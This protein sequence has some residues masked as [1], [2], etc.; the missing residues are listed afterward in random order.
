MATKRIVRWKPPNEFYS[1]RSVSVADFER[2]GILTQEVDLHWQKEKGFWLEAGDAQISDEALAWML[3][4]GNADPAMG[5][6]TYEEQE[7]K[8][9]VAAKTKTTTAEVPAP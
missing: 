7:V 9:K 6:W 5:E 4:E 3:G 1:Q 8:D 2:L